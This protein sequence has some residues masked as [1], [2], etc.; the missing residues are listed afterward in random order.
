MR[1]W[2]IHPKYLDSVGL[3]ALWRE[4]LLAQAVMHGETKGY[5]HHP[6]LQRFQQ[7]EDPLLAMSHYLRGIH[8]EALARGYHFNADKIKPYQG[9]VTMMVTKG[10][11][12]YEWQHLLNKLSQRSPERFAQFEAM[13]EPDSHPMMAVIEGEVASWEKR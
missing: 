11:L 4:T 5:R 12:Q 7:H 10:Q 6:Q 8:Q 13:I 1:L 3:V 9:T 2:S